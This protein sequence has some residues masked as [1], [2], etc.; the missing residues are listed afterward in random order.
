MDSKTYLKSADLAGCRAQLFEEIKKS[1]Q[2]TNLRVFLFQLSC[3]LTDWQKARAQLEFL[4]DC[5]SQLFEPLRL[6]YLQLLDGE[7]K[8]LNILA[9]D[10]ELKC[11]GPPPSWFEHFKLALPLFATQNFEQASEKVATALD[12]APAIKGRIDGQPFK[13]L[14]DGDSRFGLSLEIMLRGSYSWLP[15]E[16]IEKLTFEPIEDL[17]DLVWRAVNIRLKNKAEFIAFVPMRYPI[18]SLTK[19]TEKLC[20]ETS[21][22]ETMRGV[23]IGQG[24]RMLLTE[25]AEFLLSEIN[26]VEFE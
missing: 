10:A 4:R 9:G 26:V 1:P 12:I 21:W 5:N 3:V 7:E 23:F 24:Q 20:R 13:M 15:F 8:R 18:D 11:S 17:R 16:S 14:I 6:T 2:E 19:D 22:S 25:N